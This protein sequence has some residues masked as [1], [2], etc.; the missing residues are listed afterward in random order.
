MP[1]SPESPQ[2][3][4]VAQRAGQ[5]ID[6]ALRYSVEIVLLLL[7]VYLCVTRGLLVSVDVHEPAEVPLPAAAVSE[8]GLGG[9]LSAVGQQVVA[10]VF[11]TREAQVIH[12]LA[13]A[14]PVHESFTDV[15][16]TDDP[17][18]HISNLTLVLSPDYGERKGLSPA[19]IAAKRRRVRDYVNRHAE[20]ARREMRT[21]GVPASITLAQA[22]L[23]S[24]AGDSKLAVNSNN[25][26]GIKCRSK[27]LGCTCRNYGDDTRYDMF[28]VFDSVGDSFREH[29]ILLNTPR[30]ARLHTYGTDYRKW[31]HGL[32]ACGYATDKRYA[33]KLI[34]I[35]ENLELDRFDRAG[36]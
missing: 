2:L 4:A 31:A 9:W 19:V 14:Q 29:S 24:N 30:Y 5:L 3:S 21:H 32:R 17:A 22:L 12:D 16:R 26:F 10:T 33:Q 18:P 6:G 36:V 1:A 35:I 15:A 7:I 11:S 25:H 27:C 34:T 20:A 8:A 23:E 28:R 13:P